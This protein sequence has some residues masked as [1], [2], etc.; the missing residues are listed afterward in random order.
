MN[1]PAAFFDGGEHY[2]IVVQQE[3]GRRH[4]YTVDEAR[5]LTQQLLLALEQA[6]RDVDDERRMG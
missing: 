3:P 2:P 4:G 1:P 5:V 6:Q